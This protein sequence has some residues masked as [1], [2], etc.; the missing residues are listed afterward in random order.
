MD[1]ND[2][3]LTGE[4]ML[5]MVLVGISALGVMTL[6]GWFLMWLYHR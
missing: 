6:A 5:G 2:L 1:D 4:R 3:K